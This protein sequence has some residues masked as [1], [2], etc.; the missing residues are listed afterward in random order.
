MLADNPELSVR[1][2]QEL[3][4]ARV[5]AQEN[6]V[7]A[8]GRPRSRPEWERSVLELVTPEGTAIQPGMS[9]EMLN[10]AYQSFR[11]LYDQ[12]KG[13][14][15]SATGLRRSI[16]ATAKDPEIIATS[17]ERGA[18]EGWL[19]N[20][21][22]AIG[23][24]VSRDMTDS[25]SLL[26]L[27]SRIRDERRAQTKRGNM[28]RADLLGSAESVLTQRLEQ[29]LPQEVVDTL[30]SADSQYRKYKV[31]ENAL[32]NAGDSR[33]TPEQLSESIRMGG[34]TTTSR[35][36]RGV[37]PTVQELRSAALTGRDTAEVMG[38][39]RRAALLVRGLDEEGKKAVQ[40]DFIH[41]M[42][43]R[44]KDSATDV[45]DA[46][47]A[48][49]SGR[50]LVRDIAENKPV[51]RSLGM[52]GEDIT[53]VENMAREISRMEQRAPAAV[54]R[55]FE[56]GPASLLQLASVLIG[57]KSGQRMAGRGIGSSLVLA[58]Y[59]S[60]RARTVLSNLTSNQAEKLMEDAVTDPKLYKA[61]LTKNVTDR[62]AGKEQAQ[63]LESWLLAAAAQRAQEDTE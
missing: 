20:Q 41:M 59:M 36:A 57:A 42:L 13:H 17:G 27:R 63:Y 5:I 33:L 56:D 29:G 23:R 35:Y 12:A 47:T 30:R 58:Q 28:E 3:E 38:D 19:S 26:E 11:P 50:R 37:D 43:G 40:A 62:R 48:L 46:G 9:D 14:P 24:R 21:Y 16:L 44:A 10:Q 54:D 51:M 31:V 49:A 61:L 60:N 1:V 53:R 22:S 4:E 2:K 18:V 52:K 45:T 6:L 55:L 34:L 39:P 32:F 15:V 25:D 7:D 8:A